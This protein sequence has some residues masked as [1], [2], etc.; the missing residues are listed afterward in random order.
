MVYAI[1]PTAYIHIF[2][3]SMVFSLRSREII[4]TDTRATAHCTIGKKVCG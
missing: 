1:G 3:I 2:I 4:V